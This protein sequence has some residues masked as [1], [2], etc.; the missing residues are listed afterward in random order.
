MSILAKVACA[1][2]ALAPLGAWALNGGEGLYNT[3]HDFA[4][5]G[6]GAAG[7]ATNG[8]AFQGSAGGL[9]VGLC[10]FCHTPHKAQ[11]TQLLWNHKLST[12]SYSWDVPA[13]T[14]GTTFPV[15]NGATYKGPTAK[16]LSCHDGSVAIGDVAWYREQAWPAPGSL[17]DKY[18]G[19]DTPAEFLITNGTGAAGNMAGNHPV[20]MPFP[21]G[22]N[23]S[24][25]NGVT[26]GNGFVNTDWVADPTLSGS[27]HIRLF[28]DA[29]GS[30][31]AGAQPG[32]TGIECSSCHDPHN[33]QSVDDLFLRGKISGAT[34][35]D[36]YICLQCHIK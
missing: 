23:K 8:T 9:G 2:I 28:N 7:S 16:C 13:T 30:V 3:P 17:L 6:V 31:V 5:G 1:V 14:A 11:S 29:T 15:I 33:R 19:K 35:Q 25:Y 34:Q 24:T 26:T 10:T 12:N 20:A 22:Q 18:I 4:S 32:N 21:F 27:A 36:G